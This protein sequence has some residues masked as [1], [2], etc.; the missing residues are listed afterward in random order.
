MLDYIAKKKYMKID[1][2]F[3]L[4]LENSAKNKRF[5]WI[6]TEHAAAQ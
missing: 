3:D 2:T 1:L 5:G 4:I 6:H